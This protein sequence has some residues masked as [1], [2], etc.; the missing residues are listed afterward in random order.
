V[1][2]QIR[3][4]RIKVKDR[5]SS[6]SLLG[7]VGDATIVSVHDDDDERYD[8]KGGTTTT[9]DKQR[10][11]GVAILIPVGCVSGYV[12]VISTAMKYIDE[13]HEQLYAELCIVGG[14]NCLSFALDL[15]S[16]I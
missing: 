8:I 13:Y 15:L 3:H 7:S 12:N 16:Y 10:D 5:H 4:R 6:C 11:K 1:P 9:R 2:G 14:K